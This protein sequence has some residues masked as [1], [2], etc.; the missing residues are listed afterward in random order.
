METDS[1]DRVQL[2]NGNLAASIGTNTLFGMMS[3]FAQI[4][5]RLVT[6]PVVIHYLGLEGYGIWNIIMTTA[7][8]MRFGAVGVKTAYQ[9]YVAEATGNG[10][11]ETANKL[12]ST[13]SAVMVCFSVCFLIPVWASSGWI[14]KAAGVPG[15]FLSSASGAIGLL[16]IIMVMANVGA[17]FEAIVMGGHRIDLVR[18]FGTV[19]TIAESLAILLVLRLGHGLMAMAAVMGAS[20]LLYVSCCCVAARRVLPQCKVRLRY[21]SKDVL[22]ELFRYAGSYQLVNV[23]EVLYSSLLPFAILR[24]YGPRLAGAYAVVTRVVGVAGAFQEP[25]LSPILS[26]GAMVHATGSAVQMKTLVTKAFKVAL[27]LCLLPLGFIAIFGKT[28]AYVWTGQVESA[29]QGAFWLVCLRAV[30]ASL[31]LLALVLYRA[32]GKAILDN[33]RQVVRLTIMVTFVAFARRVGFYGLLAGMTLAEVLGM[34][35]MLFALT[36]TFR[37]FSARSLLPDTVR[38]AAAAALV[39]GAGVTASY[40]PIPADLAGRLGAAWRLGAISATCLLMVFPVVVC[41]GT[42]TREEGTVLMSMF[43]RKAA[44]PSIDKARP[45]E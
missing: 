30:F 35:L 25:F 17:V 10:D 23:L 15:E 21:V 19:L 37:G 14:A 12:L 7:T 3:T 9:K 38:Q 36:R 27:G 26:A 43:R 33:I 40:F 2:R 5:T 20:E 1:G 34:L 41:T 4:A 16:A 32:S 6:V 11:Y 45:Q 22:Y 13:G 8:Y 24:I 44:M 28:I 31:S 39:L 18:K 29:F 42:V